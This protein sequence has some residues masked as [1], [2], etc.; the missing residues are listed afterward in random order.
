MQHLTKRANAIKPKSY[1]KLVRWL[2]G[3]SAVRVASALHTGPHEARGPS[4]LSFHLNFE[5]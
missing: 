2:F 1:T 3:L 5:I 4:S